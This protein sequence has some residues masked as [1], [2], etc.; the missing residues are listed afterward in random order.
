MGSKGKFEELEQ[1]IIGEGHDGEGGV[2]PQLTR[3]SWLRTLLDVIDQ[4]VGT[5]KALWASSD[6][7]D[8]TSTMLQEVRG[9]LEGLD[10][11]VERTQEERN[12]PPPVNRA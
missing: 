4:D 11:F 12:Q 2:V 9:L 5:R 8:A 3:A 1:A 6:D 10:R 7:P